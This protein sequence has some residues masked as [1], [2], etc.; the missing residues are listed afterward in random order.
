MILKG[1]AVYY[2]VPVG[3][4]CLESFFPKPQGHLRNHRTFPF[5]TVHKVIAGVDIPRLLFSPG[6]ELVAPFVQAAKELE[7]EG[8]QAIT[9]SCGFMACFQA[10]LAAAVKIPV[11]LSSLVQIPLV[12]TFHGADCKIGVLT[13]SSAALKEHHFV[14]AG[15]DIAGIAIQGMEGKK[16]FWETIIEKQRNDFDVTLLEHEVV[17]AAEEL[18]RSEEID[19]LVLECTDLSRFAHAIQ[20]RIMVPVYDINALVEYIAYTVSRCRYR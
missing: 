15:A 2:D 14:A 4:L 11:V 16:E 7:H 9:G 3:I 8:V 10:E 18:A 12:R 6:P 13:A 17:A 5:P 20:Q 1:G 19:A